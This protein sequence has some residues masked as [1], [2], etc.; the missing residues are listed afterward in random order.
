MK[1]TDLIFA[2][3]AI[4]EEH[5]DLELFTKDSE[6]YPITVC[7]AEIVDLNYEADWD[8]WKPKPPNIQKVVI[9][10]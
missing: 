6:Y 4:E 2:L 7:K 5:G 1:I 3:A 8:G 10:D 9:L